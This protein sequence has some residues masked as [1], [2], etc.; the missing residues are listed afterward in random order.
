[1]YTAKLPGTFDPGRRCSPTHQPVWF[2]A[3]PIT[4]PLLRPF[5][6]DRGILRTL[7]FV[8]GLE[9]FFAA[10][11]VRSTPGLTRPTPEHGVR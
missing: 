2:D 11:L 8:H 4:D 10:V 1:M 9:A 3:T 6:T 5:V 7:P